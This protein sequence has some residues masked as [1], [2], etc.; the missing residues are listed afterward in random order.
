MDG[1]NR[2]RHGGGECCPYLGIHT[3][4][5]RAQVQR[6]YGGDPRSK[7]VT[8]ENEFPTSAILQGEVWR[9]RGV[10]RGLEEEI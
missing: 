7:A 1:S 8:T 9:L 3:W 2:S 4:V 10:H 6:E 5:S